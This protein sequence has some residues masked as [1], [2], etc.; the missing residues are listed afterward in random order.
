MT[1][2]SAAASHSSLTDNRL[3]LNG[4]RSDTPGSAEAQQLVGRISRV[5]LREVWKHEALDFTTWLE[6]NVDLLNE[7]LDLKLEN[8]EREQAAGAFSVDLVAEDDTGSPVIIENQLE[9]SNHDHLG[10]LLT[11]LTALEAKAAIWIVSD[12]RPEH[13]RVLTWLNES[14]PASFYLLKVEAIRI[15]CSEPAPL[16]TAIV[17]PSPD[18]ADIGATKHELAGRYKLRYAFWTSLLER[19][20]QRTSLHAGRSPTK[21]HWIGTGS[22]KSGLMFSYVVHKHDGQVELYIDRGPD[23]QDENLAI[24]DELE[25][26]REDIEAA[27]GEP[28]DWQRLE[29]RRACRIAKRLEAGGYRDDE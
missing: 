21:Y 2:A 23:Q 13:V 14:S 20:S 22:G 10:K 8:V 28:L 25:A 7:V 9:R 18:S 29:S 16:L 11:Y 24:F 4:R 19:A 17:R 1:A 5:P 12:P 15:G 27:F 6:H 26:K 3:R